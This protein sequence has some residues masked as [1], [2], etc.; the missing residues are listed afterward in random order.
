M[1]EYAGLGEG[2]GMP[3]PIDVYTDQAGINIGPFGC[4]LNFSLSSAVPPA[5][6]GAIPGAPVAVV[7]MSLEHLKLLTFLLRRQLLQFEQQT[8]VR[9]QVSQDVLN[10]LRIGRE[11]WDQQWGQDR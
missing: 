9:V 3:E 6:G 8:G 4:S 7:R 5:G 2:S 1:L 11:D 10:Q